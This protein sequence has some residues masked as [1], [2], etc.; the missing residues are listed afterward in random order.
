[1]PFPTRATSPE[2]AKVT[3]ITNFFCCGTT[4]TP[5]TII[6]CVHRKPWAKKGV[7][8]PC[9]SSQIPLTAIKIILLCGAKQRYCTRGYFR[10]TR[11]F[12]FYV[13]ETRRGTEKIMPEENHAWFALAT[14]PSYLQQSLYDGRYRESRQLKQVVV[15][16][17]YRHTKNHDHLCP[18]GAQGKKRRCSFLQLISNT[19]HNHQNNYFCAER[20]KDF[21]RGATSAAQGRLPFM[22]TR[23]ALEN[24][25]WFALATGMRKEYWA[26]LPAKTE[27][28]CYFGYFHDRCSGAGGRP[29]QKITP[30]SESRVASD[31]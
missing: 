12:T 25:A 11:P 21:V 3:I 7:V 22:S 24:H 27:E 6:T 19:S 14:D 13:H 31:Q 5:E 4:A 10:R 30:A 16:G 8:R 15:R 1:V 29:T 23:R 2:V 26:S 20:S 9:S 28:L 17:H 18:L